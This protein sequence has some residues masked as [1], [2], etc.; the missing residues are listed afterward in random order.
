M[1]KVLGVHGVANTYLTAP[2]LTS[3]WFEAV[4][5]GIDEAGYPAMAPGEPA[6]VAYGSLFRPKGS[7]SLRTP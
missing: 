7:G 3:S 4:Q 2:Q 6:V 5:G 1:P